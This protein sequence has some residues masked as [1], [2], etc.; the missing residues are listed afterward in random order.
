M[1]NY[2]NK[3]LTNLKGFS[4]SIVFIGCLTFLLSV[5]YIMMMAYKP[6]LVKADIQAFTKT[7]VREIETHGAIDNEIDLFASNLVQTYNFNPEP[8][9]NYEA[10]YIEGSN[11]IQIRNNFKVT[12]D[13]TSEVILL[14]SNFF[15]PIKITIPIKDSKVGISEKLWK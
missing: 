2:I 12:V 13:T 7:L 1:L 14:N 15:D 9:I 4:E 5:F 6:L 11:C 3:K 10:S 8:S